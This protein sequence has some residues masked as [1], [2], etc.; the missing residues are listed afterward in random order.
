MMRRTHSFVAGTLLAM[1]AYACG[2]TTT[3]SEGSEPSDTTSTATGSGGSTTGGVTSVTSGG[4]T[5]SS[6]GTGGTTSNLCP[7]FE[8]AE[9]TGCTADGQMCAFKNCQAPDYRDYHEL[10]CKGGAWQQTAVNACPFVESC[11]AVPPLV[12]SGCDPFVTPGPCV[13]EDPCGATYEAVCLY[14]A[15]QKTDNQ[16]SD[17]PGTDGGGAATGSGGSGGG[18]EAPFCPADAPYL[19]DPCCPAFVPEKC[20]YTGSA[21]AAGASFDFA[22]GAGATGSG[23]AP[24]MLGC[25][26]CTENMVWDYCPVE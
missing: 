25:A 21:G 7:S 24:P 11:P 13:A 4:A 26:V 5:G 15:W 1:L 14:G 20:D 16:D 8:P 3:N 2:D 18:F 23:A 9:G 19:Y 10:T 17:R 12:G 22:P 6:G